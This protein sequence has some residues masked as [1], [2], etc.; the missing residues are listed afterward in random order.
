MS[1][2]GTSAGRAAICAL[3]L[4]VIL[5]MLLVAGAPAKKHK[6]K[7]KRVASQVSISI[8]DANGQLLD[9]AGSVTSKSAKCLSGRTV[10]LSFVPSQTGIP[11]HRGNPSTDDQG[12]WALA[13]VGHHGGEGRYFA[14]IGKV[15]RGKVACKAAQSSIAFP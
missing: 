15:S 4:V 14:S 12:N 1:K 9:F 3:G 2:L 8:T 10:E 6:H 13:H 11:S 7:P 5:S